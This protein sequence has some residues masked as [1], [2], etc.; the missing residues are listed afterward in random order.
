MDYRTGR[1]PMDARLK[2]FIRAV[3]FARFAT[4]S[5]LAKFIG[6]SQATIHRV[7]SE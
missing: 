5:A 4:Q 1:P 3:Y 2:A 6:C 7:V